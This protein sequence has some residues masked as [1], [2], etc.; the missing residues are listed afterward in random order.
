MV[1]REEGE[2]E[3]EEGKRDGVEGVV[4]GVGMPSVV[5]VFAQIVSGKSLRFEIPSMPSFEDVFG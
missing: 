4:R 3:E 2:E 5:V 1:E